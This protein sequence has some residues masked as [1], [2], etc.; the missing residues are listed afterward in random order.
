VC[1]GAQRPEITT[2]AR[3]RRTMIITQ[4]DVVMLHIRQPRVFDWVGILCAGS[5][6]MYQGGQYDVGAVLPTKESKSNGSIEKADTVT[7][8]GDRQRDER[9]GRKEDMGQDIV[10]LTKG[11]AH[12]CG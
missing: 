3:Y 9:I 12:K 10:E 1:R 6:L 7:N 5:P 8:N 11:S 2:A 4:V